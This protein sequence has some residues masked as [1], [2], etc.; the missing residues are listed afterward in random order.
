NSGDWNS[1]HRNSGHRN[2]GHRNSG[3]WNS[4][5]WNSGHRNS[6]YFNTNTPESILVF[7]KPCDVAVWDESY[8][9]RFL[10]IDLTVWISENEMTDQ[11]KIDNPKFFVAG[12]YLKKRDYREVFQESWNKSDKEDRDKVRQLPN[13]DAALFKEITGIDV[14]AE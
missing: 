5:D 12:G 10:Y 13:F 2:S 1:G 6:G 4:G 11:E 3:D 8:K 7:N 9:P 14:D